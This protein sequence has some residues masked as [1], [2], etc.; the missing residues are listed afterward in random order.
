MDL[1]ISGRKAVVCAASKGLARACATALAREGVG[2]TI[3]ARTEA[4]LTQTARDIEAESAVRQATEVEMAEKM[5]K[6]TEKPD[7]GLGKM[8]NNFK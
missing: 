1:G 8:D 4:T 3:C 2:L 5:G 6:A 7:D